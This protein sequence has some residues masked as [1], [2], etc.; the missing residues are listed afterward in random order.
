MSKVTPFG[1]LDE[2]SNK[3]MPGRAP[4]S[5]KRRKNAILDKYQADHQDDYT[6]PIVTT[7]RGKKT[8]NT[9]IFHSSLPPSIRALVKSEKMKPNKR[10]HYRVDDIDISHVIPIVIKNLSVQPLINNNEIENFVLLKD[11]EWLEFTNLK[12]VSKRMEQL[13]TVVQDLLSIDFTSVR[14]P[15]SDWQSQ[16]KIDPIRVK[17]LSAAFVWYGMHPGFLVRF[18][19][20]EYIGESRDAKRI[21]EMLVNVAEEDDVNHID[22]IINEGV[23]SVCELWEPNASKMSILRRGNQKNCVDNPEIVR[24]TLNKEERNHH[25]LCVD[26]F[27]AEISPYVRITPQG[28]IIRPGK[29]KRIVWDGSTKLTPF[30]VVMNEI[31]PMDDEADISFGS[32]FNNFLSWLYNMRISFPDEIIYLSTIDIKACFRFPRIH[33]DI[34]GAFSFIVDE[35]LCLPTGHVFGSNTSASSWDP[36]RRGIEGRALYYFKLFKFDLIQ[37]HR[38]YLDMVSWDDGSLTNESENESNASSQI[39]SSRIEQSSGG[40]EVL[41]SGIVHHHLP[42]VAPT[43]RPTN[44]PT[45][46]PS[47]VPAHRC[48]INP[49]IRLG[50]EM[51]PLRVMFYV[52]DGLMAAPGRVMM[53]L[54]IASCIQGIFDVMGE[55]DLEI[56]QCPVALDKW[57]QLII[58]ARQV[59]LGILIDSEKLTAGITREYREECLTLL[60]TEWPESKYHFHAKEAL[61]MVGKLA[62]LGV[63]TPFVYYLLS[64]IYTS[65][66]YALAKNK[67]FFN[68][69]SEKFRLLAVKI[70]RRSYTMRDR[71]GKEARFA[72]KEAARMVYNSTMKYAVN[73]TMR[74][75]IEFNS[76]SHFAKR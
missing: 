63:T 14:E 9:T 4:S 64:Q 19:G 16:T 59:M 21:H 68:R 31:T 5:S 65:I 33:A 36:L 70:F 48:E 44:T 13:V 46:N 26:R 8:T 53:E 71:P 52:D 42:L 1:G 72:L 7:Q 60:N 40:N 75:E 30:D 24:E 22:R 49:G 32:T 74:E 51:C 57:E 11:I 43:E 25:I 66:T 45:A 76:T 54:L 28:I 38:E 2:D 39:A 47:I 3:A 37:R 67:E 6:S 27:L 73:K 69:S 50:V 58:A 20:G 61:R 62:R 18:M 29:N 23:P 55:P 15:R 10:K 17:M 56:R 41:E 12:Q 34:V 35:L